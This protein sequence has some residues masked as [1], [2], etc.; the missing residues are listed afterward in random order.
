MKQL[1][2]TMEVMGT[3]I[4]KDGRRTNAKARTKEKM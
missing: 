3:I 1:N 2:G 4:I